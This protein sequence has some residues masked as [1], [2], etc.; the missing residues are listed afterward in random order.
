MTHTLPG[1]RPTE[2]APPEAAGAER[3]AT[4]RRRLAEG[5]YGRPEV[6]DQ[7]AAAV[8]RALGRTH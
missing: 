7:I 2:H 5:Y 1:E 3:L 6:L 8:A 4:V